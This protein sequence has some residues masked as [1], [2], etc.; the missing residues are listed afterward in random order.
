MKQ[1]VLQRRVGKLLNEPPYGRP[2]SSPEPLGLICNRPVALD[3]TENTNFYWLKAIECAK[4]IK[5]IIY[6]A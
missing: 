4:Q 5:N 1:S 2:F 3:A 6:C